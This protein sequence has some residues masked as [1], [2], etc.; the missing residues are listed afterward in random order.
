MPGA[1]RITDIAVNPAD[2]HTVYVTDGTAVFRVADVTNAA[3]PFVRITGNLAAIGLQSLKTLEYVDNG[4][5]D[6]LLA[7]GAGGVARLLNPAAAT[8]AAAV[9]T[10]F[11]SGLPNT[12]V[13][14]IEYIDADGNGLVNAGD[15]LVAGTLGRGVWTVEGASIASLAQPSVL[16][17]LGADGP[18]AADHFQVSIDPTN[19]LRFQVQDLAAAPGTPMV[20]ARFA[21]FDQVEIHT[22]GG[23]DVVTINHTFDP[24]TVPGGIIIDGGD[25]TDTLSFI[26]GAHASRKTGIDPSGLPF[27]EIRDQRGPGNWSSTT[28]SRR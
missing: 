17:I 4:A 8:A 27:V 6:I 24:V 3:S 11:G 2:W 13:N 9:W 15:R 1:G 12:V 19:P 22:R 7:G 25:G 21:D 14:D 26:G 16:R 28:T 23:D 18:T 20:T 5:T 10:R